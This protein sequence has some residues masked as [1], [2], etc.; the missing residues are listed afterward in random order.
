MMGERI[1]KKH[2]FPLRVKEDLYRECKTLTLNHDMSMNLLF[3]EM[4]QFA[5]QNGTFNEFL[6]RH[7]KLDD[8]HG[9]YVHVRG[10]N[11]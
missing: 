10:F 8:R 11:K 7:Y 2:R 4:I 3:N 9:H 1:D 5:I 6:Q